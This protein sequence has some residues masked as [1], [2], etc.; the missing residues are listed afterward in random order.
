MSGNL[1][2]FDTLLTFKTRSGKRVEATPLDITLNADVDPIVGVI[3]RHAY[4]EIGFRFLMRD[5]LQIALAPA[6]ADAWAAIV[7][8]PP[9]P[10]D[11]RQALEAYREAFVLDDDRFPA[12]Q[13]RPTPERLAEI[14]NQKPR[15]TKASHEHDDDDDGGTE[16]IASLLP[17][18]PTKNVVKEGHDFFV[19]RDT[20]RAIGA[21]AILPV[22]Y[23]H[24]VL[25]PPSGGGYF[26]LPH[27]IDSLKFAVASDT[28]WRSIAANLFDRQQAAMSSGSWPAPCDLTVFP[29][30]DPG[31]AALSLKR[32]HP[33]ARRLVRRSSIHPAA[34]PLP[35]RYLLCEPSQQRCN[36]TGVLGPTFARYERWPNGLQYDSR[37]W[38]APFA[39]SVEILEWTGSNWAPRKAKPR[40]RP[41]D[42][43]VSVEGSDM[44]ASSTMF[45]KSRGPLR[46]DQW[47]EL[48]LDNPPSPPTADRGTAKQ[49]RRV[50]RPPAVSVFAA[51]EPRL[52]EE[53]G[54]TSQRSALARRTGF[55]LEAICAVLDG[56][57]LGGFD[58]GSLP[59]WWARDKAAASVAEGVRGILRASHLIASALE[60]A[61]K[62]AAK[63]LDKPPVLCRELHNGLLAALDARLGEATQAMFRAFAEAADEDQARETV[64]TL[65]S[66]LVRIAGREALGLFDSSFP[67]ATIDQRAIRIVGA[68]RK[69]ESALSRIVASE[70]PHVPT[71]GAGGQMRVMAGDPDRQAP[72]VG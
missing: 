64:L 12:M 72:L 39:A 29:W 54:R 70:T 24:T 44:E 2:W 23:A 11:L 9:A 5:I 50:L 18:A 57:A 19:K 22:L 52:A 43:E 7:A 36:L 3:A 13:V 69:L 48:S 15:G 60:S 41:D 35:R 31:L 46:F 16:P 4:V 21:G 34:I 6:D 32:G 38:W 25:F 28:L 62:N 71:V 53:L 45:L 8:H 14:A 51:R 27:G 63:S 66:D 20:V 59:L 67:F 33:E 55:R 30:L 56:K 49:W 68:R 47:L 40:A 65:R 37:N 17:D 10:N 61:A 26:S 42:D 58:Q 1:S